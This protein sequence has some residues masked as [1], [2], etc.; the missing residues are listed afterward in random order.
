[1]RTIEEAQYRSLKRM[2]RE[3]GVSLAGVIRRLIGRG[4]QPE[5]RARPGRAAELDTGAA[6]PSTEQDRLPADEGA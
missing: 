5:R 3:Q 6:D 1:M 2:A 4:R